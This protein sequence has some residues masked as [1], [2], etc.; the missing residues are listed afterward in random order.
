V[1]ILHNFKLEAFYD[2]P[3]LDRL[4]GRDCPSL[5]PDF[6][7][8]DVWVNIKEASRN[9]DHQQIHFNFVHRAYLTPRKL[10]LMK[11]LT[12]PMCSTG[13]FLHMMWECPPVAQF[14]TQVAARLS[15]LVSAAIPVTVPVLLLNNLTML[16]LNSQHKRTV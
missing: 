12:D 8:K 16:N 14:W 4:W 10:Y 3:P 15:D 1:S 6:N 7:W 13:T 2:K 11:R 9:P 5:Y